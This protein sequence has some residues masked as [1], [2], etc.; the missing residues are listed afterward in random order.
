M[1]IL[2]FN[3][4]TFISKRTEGKYSRKWLA[5]FPSW[6]LLSQGL[7]KRWTVLMKSLLL[8]KDTGEWRGERRRKRPFEEKSYSSFCLQFCFS[9]NH[10]VRIGRLIEVD[11]IYWHVASGKQGTISDNHKETS[12]CLY[13]H[14]AIVPCHLLWLL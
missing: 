13:L 6:I 1:V 5:H 7:M 4:I 3:A 14:P 12:F 11:W 2:A 9:N 10:L 8:Y